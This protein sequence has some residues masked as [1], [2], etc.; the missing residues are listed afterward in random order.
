M[1]CL[2]GLLS[3]IS[4]A[5]NPVTGKS[6]LSLVSEG[7]EVHLGS[8]SFLTTQQAQGGPYLTDPSVI[9]Y[10]RSVGQKLANVSD[11][12]GLPYEFTVI[13][14]STPN[15]WTLPGGKIAINRGLLMELESEAELAAVLS[16]EIVHAAARHGAKNLERGML[17]QSGMAGVAMAAQ[18]KEYGEVILGA[19]SVGLTLVKQRYSRSAELEADRFGIAYMVRA[20]YDPAAAVKLQELFVKLSQNKQEGWIT[21]LFATHPPSQERVEANKRSAAAYPPGGYIG[22]EE[23]EKAMH[24]LKNTQT[25][26]A[27][28]EEGRLALEAGQSDKALKLAQ[29][30]ID[31]EPHEGL[32]LCLLGEAKIQKN[33]FQGALAAFDRALIYHSN[34]YQI[35][36]QRGLL[37]QKLGKNELAKR[38]LTTS[39][40]LLPT[41]DAHHAL[42][43][44]ALKN[45]EQDQAL[46][47]FTTASHS[48]NTAG[49]N[50]QFQMTK[51]E[52]EKNPTKYLQTTFSIHDN[53]TL[54]LDCT[55][56]SPYSIEQAT[57]SI[58]WN[59]PSTR[60]KRELKIPLQQTIPSKSRI[61]QTVQIAGESI[62]ANRSL[63]KLLKVQVIEVKLIERN[64]EKD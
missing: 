6:E 55:N 8:E 64:R 56:L 15:A 30:A 44:L 63:D 9:Q 33:D 62:S 58:Q 45:D 60:Q 42:G 12:P 47:H 61:S 13:N 21:G 32:F 16:H 22:K 11:R 4:C 28:Y 39:T 14:N 41:S 49:S 54:R 2:L 43:L 23:Y 27:K 59:D 46:A 5:T 20:G 53:N 31:G 25:A 36:L 37:Y 40:Q 1:P 35:Y 50:S 24:Y 3:L 18:E 52:I 51:I 19:S 17:M 10:V 34:Y 26:Y 29:E 48:S 7:Q 38:D 57:F